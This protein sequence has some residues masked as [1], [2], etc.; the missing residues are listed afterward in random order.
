M[1]APGLVTPWLRV[2]CV[3][4]AILNADLVA[5]LGAPGLMSSLGLRVCRYLCVPGAVEAGWR[6]LNIMSPHPQNNLVTLALFEYYVGIINIHK[7][8]L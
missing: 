8:I 7:T 6:C 4:P 1:R 5:M 2:V 3:S